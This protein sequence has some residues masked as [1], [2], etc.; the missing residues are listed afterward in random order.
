MSYRQRLKSVILP[1]GL[2]VRTLPLGIARGI[3]MQIDFAHQTKMYLGLYEVE[4]NRHLRRACRPHYNCFDVGGQF[5]YDAL[6][7]AKLT[8]GR[9]ISF[10]CDPEA[11]A[12]MQASLL[13]NPQHGPR[14][15]IR[16]TFVSAAA[17]SSRGHSTLDDAAFSSEGFVPDFMKIDIEGCEYDALKGARR[18]LETRWPSLIV[19]THTWRLEE[20]CA[21][22][23]RGFG[24]KLVVV[25]NRRWL[26]DYRPAERNSWLIAEGAA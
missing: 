1:S 10:E 26:R 11:C 17:D 3:R 8:G 9:V 12:Q 2:R 7:M 15:E 24:Y 21:W 14:V 22:Y 23:L 25:E 20:E 4:L 16:Q 5:G 6:V 18:I 13:A 19:E